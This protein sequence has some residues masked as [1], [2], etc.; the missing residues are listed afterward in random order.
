MTQCSGFL[1][2][3]L[4]LFAIYP[5]LC[6]GFLGGH[7]DKGLKGTNFFRNVFLLPFALSFVRPVPFGRGCNPRQRII[8]SAAC[9][10]FRLW[11]EPAYCP[12]DGYACIILAL[13]C[14]FP[15]M[16]V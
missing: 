9:D 14:S 7:L 16:L 3:T 12:R 8:N 6:W 10:G 11:Q 4:L 15:V 5:S 2:N 13:V 1:E